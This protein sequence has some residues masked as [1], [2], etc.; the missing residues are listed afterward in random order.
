MNQKP[1]DS[2][3]IRVDQILDEFGCTICFVEMTDATITKC[4]HS[5]CKDCIEEWINRNHECP[6]C[7]EKLA[8]KDLIKNYHFDQIISKALA[9]L[10]FLVKE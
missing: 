8:V 5:F 10:G 1:S 9:K 6:T 3:K 4:G 7:K 2:I